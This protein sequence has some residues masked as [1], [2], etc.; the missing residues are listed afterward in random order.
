MINSENAMLRERFYLMYGKGIWAVLLMRLKKNWI[1]WLPNYP[2]GIFGVE[3]PVWKPD[4]QWKNIEND[5]TGGA[6]HYFPV[7]VFRLPQCKRSIPEFDFHTI[8]FNW[9]RS[10]DLFLGCEFIGGSSRWFHCLVWIG[11]GNRNCYGDLPQRCHA[12]IGW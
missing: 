4:T 1:K 11:S 12:A 3:R 7:N 2:R 9:W 8:C 10:N 6:A 5:F